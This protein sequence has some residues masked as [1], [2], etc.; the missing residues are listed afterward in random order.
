MALDLGVDAELDHLR[1][2]Q[3]ELQFGRM[4]LVK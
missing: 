2:D 3:D 1:I 4:L